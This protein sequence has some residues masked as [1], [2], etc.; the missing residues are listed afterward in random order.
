MLIIDDKHIKVYMHRI[1]TGY[2]VKS[3][4]DHKNRNGLDNR[5]I[6]LSIVSNSENQQ[7]KQLQRNNTNGATS[8]NSNILTKMGS[9][10]TV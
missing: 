3:M 10:V 2:P 7:N 4:A 5:L 8:I 6:N 9:K 1:L